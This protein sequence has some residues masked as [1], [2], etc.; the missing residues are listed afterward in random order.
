MECRDRHLRYILLIITPPAAWGMMPSSKHKKD[1]LALST[2]LLRPLPHCL[3]GAPIAPTTVI[4][5]VS[6][7]PPASPIFVATHPHAA[8]PIMLSSALSNL[9]VGCTAS[10]FKP[11]RY[12]HDPS[13]HPSAD[14]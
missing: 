13:V 2:A 3:S 12:A 1:Q 7:L 14:S 4:A 10:S 9:G 6:P 8:H 11:V 5:T